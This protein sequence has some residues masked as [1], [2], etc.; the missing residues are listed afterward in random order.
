MS[1]SAQWGDSGGCQV[2]GQS[3]PRH[4]QG[5][6][7]FSWVT[8]QSSAH[9]SLVTCQGRW[10]GQRWP[11][12]P[13]PWAAGLGP[14]PL[15]LSG[16]SVGTQVSGGQLGG[17]QAPSLASASQKG[18]TTKARGGVP[19]SRELQLRTDT[20][21]KFLSVFME[22]RSLEGGEGPPSTPD[23]QCTSHGQIPASHLAGCL[24]V[25]QLPWRYPGSGVAISPS[26]SS[27]LTVGSG[28]ALFWEGELRG[29]GAVVCT[30]AS[31]D[32]GARRRV[33]RKVL[34]SSDQ[35]A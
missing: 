13:H 12:T 34:P 22:V 28:V 19:F 1:H 27:A 9:A 18:H 21:N 11:G 6:L 4:C 20:L 17:D 8:A 35:R 33:T 7:A 31:S 15:K 23:A 2:L 14:W 25:S 5:Q 24:P 29:E 10:H 26:S 16:G 3:G 30:L 32:W